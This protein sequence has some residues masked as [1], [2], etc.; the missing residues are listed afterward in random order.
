MHNDND[1]LFGPDSDS[2]GSSASASARLRPKENGVMAFH[3]GTEQ[4]MLHHVRQ[5]L[6]S[7]PAPA[8]NDALAAA[9]RV[10]E[11]VDDFCLTKHWM[12]HVG[13]DKA[14]VLADALA[15]RTAPVGAVLELGT[16]CG[17]SAVM[18][19]KVR[20]ACCVLCVVCL[21]VRS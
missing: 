7:L 10:L 11:A 19:C 13:A 20:G 14:A 17:Y 4:M 6:S 15:I 16:Y 3:S 21:V 5:T 8:A 2:E 9:E 12:M 1:D 18:V